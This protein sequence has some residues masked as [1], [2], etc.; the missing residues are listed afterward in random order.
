MRRNVRRE[1][2]KVTGVRCSKGL[3]AMVNYAAFLFRLRWKP[4]KG[5]VE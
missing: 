4:R 3:E 5:F 2:D 1:A